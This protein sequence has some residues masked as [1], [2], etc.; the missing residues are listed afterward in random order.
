MSNNSKSL[1]IDE[2]V[3]ILYSA[4]EIEINKEEEM[5]QSKIKEEAE[6]TKKYD[7]V[8]EHLKD[9]YFASIASIRHVEEKANKY[10][11]F[12]TVVFTGIFAMLN[13]S[14][15]SSFYLVT[16]NNQVVPWTAYI[17]LIVS[18]LL[19]I[20]LS[21]GLYHIVRGIYELIKCLNFYE[22]RKLP[23]MIESLEQ[24]Q[25]ESFYHFQE[26]MCVAYQEIIIHN[27]NKIKDKQDKLGK[28]IRSINKMLVFLGLAML[29]WG[30]LKFLK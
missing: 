13:T 23:N 3:E 7:V 17:K 29:L 14:F 25:S 8:L 5:K 15:E 12:V 22:I 20:C 19:V 11:A 4:Y 21:I 1:S 26:V 2:K 24:I 9:E 6:N 30:C 27:N 28:A 10:F 18:Y 16:P